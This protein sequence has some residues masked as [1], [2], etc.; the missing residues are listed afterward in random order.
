MKNKFKYLKK[1]FKVLVWPIIFAL[2][3]LSV[4]YMFVALFNNKEQVNMT[5][6]EFLDYIKTVEYQ[7]KLNNYINSKSLLIILIVSIIFLPIL[8]KVFKKYIYSN[9]FWNKYMFNL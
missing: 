6:V 7:E 3:T 8:Y 4:N 9:C 5:D 2:G 1:L